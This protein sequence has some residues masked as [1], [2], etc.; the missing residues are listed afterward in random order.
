MSSIISPNILVRARARTS[1]SSRPAA[2]LGI[3][4]IRGKLPKVHP[5][6]AERPL[7]LRIQC[8]IEDERGIGRAIEPA[9]VLHLGLEL[10]RRSAGTTE[11]K[12]RPARSR[13]AREPKRR[14]DG[15]D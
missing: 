5:R 7:I 8:G 6:L 9:I 14:A 1:H 3:T 10:T 4:G 15:G 2:A 12:Q 11:G 13:A